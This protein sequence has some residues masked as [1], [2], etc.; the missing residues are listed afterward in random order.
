M[1]DRIKALILGDGGAGGNGADTASG[2]DDLAVAAVALLVEAAVMDGDFDDAE[3]WVRS[4][5]LP[6]QVT[7]GEGLHPLENSDEDNFRD[8][9]QRFIGTLGGVHNEPH[10]GKKGTTDVTA[11]VLHTLIDIYENIVISSPTDL[12]VQFHFDYEDED[13]EIKSERADKA[14]LT[15]RPRSAKNL[16][17]RVPSW[18]PAESVKFS[19][20]GKPI[21]PR[22]LGNFAFFGKERITEGV[23][24]SYDLPEGRTEEEID[25]TRYSFSWRGDEIT[26]VS[27]N[28]DFLPFYPTAE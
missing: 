22:M 11:A 2:A 4:R 14:K 26:G 9:S 21:E 5:L 8:L 16:Q 13:I 1:I 24:M 3:R 7:E 27:P 28:T 19:S 18:T 15:I 6:C 25:G 10:G 20:G 12:K 23:Q 17:V